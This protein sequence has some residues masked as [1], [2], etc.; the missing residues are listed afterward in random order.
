MDENVIL[1][2]N[3]ETDMVTWGYKMETFLLYVYIAW[4]CCMKM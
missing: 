2:D 1:S 3:I 4:G